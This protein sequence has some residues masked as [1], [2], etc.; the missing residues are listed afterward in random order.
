MF[1]RFYRLSQAGKIGGAVL[2]AA[3]LLWATSGVQVISQQTSQLPKQRNPAIA[4]VRFAAI[5]L[6][7]QRTYKEEK[8]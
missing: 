8:S 5:I 4:S 3:L 7:A 2:M 1:T 6:G